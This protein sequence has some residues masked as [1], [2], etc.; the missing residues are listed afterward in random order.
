MFKSYNYE[1]APLQS[2]KFLAYLFS[3]MCL[4]S[5]IFFATSRKENDAII[6]ASLICSVFLD[7][8]YVLGQS[9]VDKYVQMAKIL[10]KKEEDQ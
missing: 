7:V 3:N 2:K 9:Y 8:G 4:K 5:Y 1:K 6:L 10:S